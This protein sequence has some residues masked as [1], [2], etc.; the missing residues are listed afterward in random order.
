MGYLRFVGVVFDDLL[1]FSVKTSDSSDT[2]FFIEFISKG[3]SFSASKD[4]TPDTL[5]TTVVFVKPSSEV[6][7]RHE[8][9]TL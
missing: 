2:K 5:R 6:R 1:C 8:M 3:R 7:A 9:S 4:V